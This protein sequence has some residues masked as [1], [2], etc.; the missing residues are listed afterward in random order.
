MA[1]DHKARGSNPLQ[2]AT[3]KQSPLCFD[4]FMQK[5][6]RPLPCFSFFEK[7]HARLTCSF[8]N[9]RT[10]ARCRYH[11]F[12]SVPTAQKE[13]LFFKGFEPWEGESRSQTVRG[14]VWQANGAQTGT[15][16]RKPFGRQA[17]QGKSLA[18]LTAR[19]QKRHPTGCLFCIC[20]R[21]TQHHYEL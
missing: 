11:L 15:E 4:F 19:H 18:S 13:A 2:R 17:E 7:R 8:V 9:A 12:S 6:V 16:R 21:R 20:V 5:I 3:S 14:T 1:T 10:T